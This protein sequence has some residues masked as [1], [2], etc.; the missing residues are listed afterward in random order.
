MKNALTAALLIFVALPAITLAQDSPTALDH[1]KL[2]AEK[3][4]P[5]SWNLANYEE[6]AQAERDGMQIAA[7]RIYKSAI[8]PAKRC[9]K[10][11]SG[12]RRAYLIAY[13]VDLMQGLVNDVDPVQ[14]NDIR[15]SEDQLLEQALA[16]KNLPDDLRTLLEGLQ[17]QE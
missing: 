6:A 11:T 10:N 16:M 9:I 1:A 15:R 3:Y 4:C 12:V 2:V 17:A 7:V 8:A 13:T 14:A 5:E